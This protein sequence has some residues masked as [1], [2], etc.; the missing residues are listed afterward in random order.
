MVLSLGSIG[1]RQ[2]IFGLVAIVLVLTGASC[3]RHRGSGT[4]T[5]WNLVGGLGVNSSWDGVLLDANQIRSL[6]VYEN[7][8]YAGIISELHHNASVWEFDGMSW[9][10]VAGDTLY[11]SWSAGT[12]R[13]VY[14]LAADND[15]LYAG[16]GD[17]PG[18][19]EVWRYDGSSWVQIGGDGVLSSWPESTHDAVWSLGVH[20]GSVYAGLMTER[21]GTNQALLYRF[22]GNSWAFMTGAN[23]E[24][25]G[26]QASDDYIMT[27]VLVSDGQY[28][29]VGLAGRATGTAEVWRF[30]GSLFSKIGGDGVNQSWSDGNIKYVEDLI[31]YNGRLHAGLQRPQGTPANQS[32]VWEYD[33]SNW[34]ALG[35]TVPTDWA[36][37][38]IFNKLLPYRN[39]LY[40]AAGGANYAASVWELQSDESWRKVAGGGLDGSVWHLPISSDD[41]G[42]HPLWTYSMIEYQGRLLVGMASSAVA[43][44][45][46]V[47]QYE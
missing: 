36:D 39:K 26:W 25:G 46:Q 5:R 1:Y 11:G 19:A 27:Y 4:D 10:Q 24:L 21:S 29:F 22:D 3:N 2:L 35:S 45:G 20:Q 8:I 40:V 18:D 7:K 31:V 15:Y 17:F 44:R 16:L 47:W 9:R 12:K 6:V 42:G 33:G 41:A 23:G 43:G 34:R 14:A 38:I 32:S 37:L 28:L 13:G 30:D